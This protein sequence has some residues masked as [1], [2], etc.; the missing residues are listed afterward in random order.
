LIPICILL[1]LLFINSVNGFFLIDDRGPD[2]NFYNSPLYFEIKK[3]I[4]FIGPSG[5]SFAD[6]LSESCQGGSDL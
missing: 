5:K 3:K 6:Y 1:L 4:N 2:G